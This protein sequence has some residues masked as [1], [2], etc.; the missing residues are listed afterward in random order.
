MGRRCL[1]SY[2]LCTFL[3]LNACTSD[4]DQPDLQPIVDA[5]WTDIEV[6]PRS[7][8][9]QEQID[10]FVAANNM[11]TIVS[12]EG[13]VYV[14]QDAGSGNK[15]TLDSVVI[16]RY[17]GYFTDGDVFDSTD[18]RQASRFPLNRVIEAWQVGL[19]L[20]GEGGRI[21]MLVRPRLGYGSSGNAQAGIT[22][23]NVL[24]FE[25]QLDEVEGS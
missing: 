12:P 9:P 6:T 19:P 7:G 21:W 24:V 2:A 13:L 10:R 3:L 14:I 23:D 18:G 11:D 15:P 20:I 5:T 22:G 4:D 17:K 8:T 1:L 16:A 25:I